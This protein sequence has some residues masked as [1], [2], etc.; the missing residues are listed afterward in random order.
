MRQV[1]LAGCDEVERC[2]GDDLWLVYAV[3]AHGREQR[4]V[5]LHHEP[6]ERV[7]RTL[8][9]RVEK[10]EKTLRRAPKRTCIVG[11]VLALCAL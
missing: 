7:D 8:Q 2:F 3:G 1:E 6:M 11:R 9:A 5:R 10:V 4:C